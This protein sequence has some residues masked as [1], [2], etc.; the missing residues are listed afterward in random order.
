LPSAGL[1]LASITL[2][3]GT[4]M[5]I[6]LAIVLIILWALGFVAFHVGGGLIHLLLVIAL[7]VIVYR[8][9]TGRK[10]A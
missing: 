1:G 4:H 3:E 10:V 7:I 5:L 2:E 8:L 9:L 6:T